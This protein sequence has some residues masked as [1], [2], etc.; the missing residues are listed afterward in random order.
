[1]GRKRGRVRVK[2]KRGEGEDIM[3]SPVDRLGRRRQCY[4][5]LYPNRR[6]RLYHRNNYHPI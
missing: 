5:I 6:R 2:M 3:D 4:V 1:M